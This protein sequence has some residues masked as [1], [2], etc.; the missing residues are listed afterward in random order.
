MAAKCCGQKW[1]CGCFLWQ[2][3]KKKKEFVECSCGQ[4][5]TSATR[6]FFPDGRGAGDAIRSAWPDADALPDERELTGPAVTDLYERKDADDLPAGSIAITMHIFDPGTSADVHVAD[7]LLVPGECGTNKT[8][9]GGVQLVMKHFHQLFVVQ[10]ATR[11]R[12][13]AQGSKEA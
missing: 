7:C 3:D 8:M 12:P 6:E 2:L 1:H 9:R 10:D 13:M 5:V 4:P 11:R